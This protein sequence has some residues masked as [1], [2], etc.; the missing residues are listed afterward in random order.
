MSQNIIE[1]LKS[2]NPAI[3]NSYQ[4]AFG[5]PTKG[6]YEAM[7]LSA[8][9]TLEDYPNQ[10]ILMIFMPTAKS[11]SKPHLERTQDIRIDIL[12]LFCNRLHQ[13]QEFQD[14]D[15]EFIASEL[16]YE[17]AK[18]GKSSATINTIEALQNACNTVSLTMGLDNLWDLPYWERVKE[19][20]DR[21]RKIY[22][23]Q[24]DV[25]ASEAN[26][27]GLISFPEGQN[28]IKFLP[29]ASWNSKKV[30]PWTS[31]N[32]TIKDKLQTLKIDLLGKPT[33]TSSS[34]LRCALYELYGEDGTQ[35]N[36]QFVPAVKV[37][38]GSIP[39]KGDFWYQFHMK[40]KDLSSKKCDNH[41]FT[42][43]FTKAG[44][45]VSL[46]GGKRT[47][48]YRRNQ[49]KRKNRTSRK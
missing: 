46:E 35:F 14:K 39:Q 5:P 8:Q 19:Y 6:H 11:S 30:K 42:T 9:K 38:Q 40:I 10:T 28:I 41:T 2:K 31:I 49:R 13:E 21:L 26:L 32:S 43:N 16:E 29:Q 33:A 47:R 12:Q 15:I 27:L 36:E 20:P 4:G 23:P 18:E 3:L 22:V 17:L 37:L 34:L 44:L 25:P 48:K 24:R 7:K 45:K 1:A